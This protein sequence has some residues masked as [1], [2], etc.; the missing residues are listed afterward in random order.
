[1]K[2]KNSDFVFNKGLFVN[3]FN[4]SHGDIAYTDSGAGDYTLIFLHGLPTSKELWNPVLSFLDK[5]FRRVCFDLNNY[6]QSQKIAYHISHKERADVLDELR[7][8]LG[9]KDFILVA[10]DLGSSVAIDY[11]GKYSANVQSLI[12]MSSPVYPDFEEPFIIKL[13]RLPILGYVLALVLRPFLFKKG[14]R[15]GL[16]NKER[17]T[18]SFLS[19]FSGA[20][21]GKEGRAAFLRILRWGRPHNVFKDYPEI[22]KNIHIP[23]L[24]LHGRHDPY[25][26]ISHAVRLNRD[27]KNSKLVFI[28]NGGHFL[29][30]D[31]PDS[32]AEAI[33]GF[34]MRSR[35]E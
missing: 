1:M 3:Y 7:K 18:T 26:P 11:M 33:N 8:Y 14:I 22:I 35:G 30:I 9:I 5:N 12:L 4:S 19:A 15:K 6:G 21:G 34:L 16:V 27:I 20:F 23:T 24:I 13:V 32:I 28:E 29:P 10:H 17:F 25:I 2:K 31:T